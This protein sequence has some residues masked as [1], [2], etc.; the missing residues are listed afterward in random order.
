MSVKADPSPSPTDRSDVWTERARA[1]VGRFH[2]RSTLGRRL[3][4]PAVVGA[5]KGLMQVLNRVEFHHVERLEAA[6]AM[7]RPLL[8][9]SNHVSLFDDPWLMATMSGARWEELRWI[10]TDAL[11]FFDTPVKAWFFSAGKGVP[12]VRGAGLDQ[13][14]FHFL[15]EKLREGEWVHVFPEGTRSRTPLELHRPFK[16]GLAFLIQAARPLLLPFHHRGMEG[17]LPIGATFPRFRN[18]VHVRFGEITDAAQGL[19]DASIEDITRWAEEELLGLQGE[20][21]AAG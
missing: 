7:G 3:L 5:C 17:V 19:A 2:P 16:P 14:G 20:A 1:A 10:A 12:I 4:A 11:N 8:T 6:R 15:E 18:T 9:F 21:V 13:P